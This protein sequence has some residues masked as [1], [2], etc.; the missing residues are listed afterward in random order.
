MTGR[1]CQCSTNKDLESLLEEQLL[2]R[3]GPMI[4]NDNLRIVL[5]YPSMEAFRQ[6]LSRQTVPVPVFGL[7]NRRG[8]YAL[9][10][11]VA[12][13]LAKQRNAAAAASNPSG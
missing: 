4:S 13:W 5:G 1:D 7:A 6:A 3:Y 12:R 10:T 2:G 9:A 8:K 11:D